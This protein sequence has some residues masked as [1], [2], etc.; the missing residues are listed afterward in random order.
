MNGGY[1]VSV[2]GSLE[3][4]SKWAIIRKV[5][6]PASGYINLPLTT[7]RSGQKEGFASH[8]TGSTATGSW[9][10]CS[11]GVGPKTLIH[12]MYSVPYSHDFHSNW[13]AIAVCSFSSSTCKSLNAKKMYKENYSFMQRKEYYS[14]ISDTKMCNDDVC[15]IGV[16]GTSHK[17]EIHFKVYPRS[18]DNTAPVIKESFK[19]SGKNENDWNNFIKWQF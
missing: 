9:V 17:P 10:H 4:F 13:L 7:V 18:F 8:K 6:T 5:C 1:S 19:K 16:M 11:L 3:N 15:V 12:F 14:S 2:S